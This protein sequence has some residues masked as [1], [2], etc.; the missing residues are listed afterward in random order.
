MGVYGTYTFALASRVDTLDRNAVLGLF[1]WS[2]KEPCG[3]GEIDIEFAR[4]GN[5]GDPTNAQYVVQ[6]YDVAKHLVRFTQPA[7]AA[8]LHRFTWQKGFVRW[9]SKGED[10]G[11]IASNNYSGIDVPVAGDERVRVNFWL[12][13]GA[14]PANGTPAEVVLSSFAF[15]K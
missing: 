5:A 4:W 12:V 3:Q 15:T 1:T 8:S 2:G 13:E 7:D 11:D 10:G 9:E 14:A 6:P